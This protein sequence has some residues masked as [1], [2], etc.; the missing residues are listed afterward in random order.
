MTHDLEL[1]FAIA[2]RVALLKQGRIV[3]DGPA[4][5]VRASGNADLREF[6]EGDSNAPI[7]GGASHG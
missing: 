7:A 1:A 4:Q 2:D 6:I 3:V 5:E